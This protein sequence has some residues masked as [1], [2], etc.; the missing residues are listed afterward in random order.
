MGIIVEKATLTVVEA[1]KYIGLGKTKVYELVKER[2]VPSI[3]IGRKILIP[4]VALDQWLLN[5]VRG[6][7]A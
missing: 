1:A 2:V 3:R 5:Q 4:K 6:I 7:T